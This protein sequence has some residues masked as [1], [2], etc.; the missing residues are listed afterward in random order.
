MSTM[1][2]FS[3]NTSMRVTGTTVDMA[4]AQSAKAKSASK[5]GNG[6]TK[7]RAQMHRRSRTGTFASHL[8]SQPAVTNKPFVA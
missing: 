8:H 6:N 4:A 3:H 5:A 1:P 7:S 2:T